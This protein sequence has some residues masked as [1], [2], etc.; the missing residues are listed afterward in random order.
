MNIICFIAGLII[1]VITLLFIQGANKTNHDHE[2]FTEGYTTGLREHKKEIP[3][4]PTEDVYGDKC[5]VC[6]KYVWGFVSKMNYCANCGQKIDWGDDD[7]LY[8]TMLP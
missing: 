1:G 8:N 3:Q 2:L 7:E 6:G 4:K 5:P